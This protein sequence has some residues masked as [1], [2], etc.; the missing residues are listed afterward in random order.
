MLGLLGALAF[1]IVCAGAWMSDEGAEQERRQYSKKTGADTYVDKKGR[2]RYTS[3][4]KMYDW[5]AWRL[6]ESRHR[7]M[8]RYNIYCK[9]H[10][11]YGLEPELTF[12]EWFLKTY[13]KAGWDLWWD[14]EFGDA[15]LNHKGI[16]KEVE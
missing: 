13:E 7:E 3:N 1:G 5:D 15:Y 6:K 2:L 8:R 10:E 14:K 16:F 9:C 11:K 4:N 12:G